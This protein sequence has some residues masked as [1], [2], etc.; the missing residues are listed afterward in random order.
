MVSS[1]LIQ[2]TLQTSYIFQFII[3]LLD[4]YLHMFLSTTNSVEMLQN[5][6]HK[7]EKATELM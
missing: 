1:Q 4:V 5:R 7:Y 2:Y 3:H 6:I